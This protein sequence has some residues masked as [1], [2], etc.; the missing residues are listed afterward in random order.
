ALDLADELSRQ[1]AGSQDEDTVDEG[2]AAH[3]AVRDGTEGQE[4]AKDDEE[5]RDEGPLGDLRVWKQS[6]E[7][8][9]EEERDA[10]RL[11]EARREFAEVVNDPEIVEIVVVE[12]DDAAGGQ[13]DRLSQERS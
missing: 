4:E 5:A 2:P 7:R 6:V 1:R 13:G 11:K 9:E 8:G 12:S 10:E 3:H